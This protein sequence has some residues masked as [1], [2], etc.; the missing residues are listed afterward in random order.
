[1]RTITTTIF[2][3][4]LAC[5][6]SAYSA[7]CA[8]FPASASTARDQ[9]GAISVPLRTD[10]PAS[11]PT[12]AHPWSAINFRTDWQAYIGAVLGELR[13]SKIAIRQHGMAGRPERS[14]GP[15]RG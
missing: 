14:I 1:M 8:R 10:Y 13:A 2:A 11:A 7:T 12:A 3:A 9:N 4:L 6:S 15:R 5:G